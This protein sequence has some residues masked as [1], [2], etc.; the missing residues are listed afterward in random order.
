MRILI[1]NWKDRTHPNAGG[2]EEYTQQ[3][4]KRLVELDH[5]VTLFVSAVEG[6][7]TTE[8]IDG[9]RVI[10]RGSRLGVYSEAKRF[11]GTE[12]AGSFD[13]VVDESNTRPFL[14]PRYVRTVPV[15]GLIHQVAREVWHYETPFPVALAGRYLFEPRWLR[16]YRDVP[17]MTISES[18]AGSLRQYGIKNT[19][20]LPIGADPTENPRVE[21]A[22]HPTMLFLGRLS[23]NKRPDH[24][25]E[26]FRLLRASVPDARLWMMGDGPM[27]DQLERSLPPG[28]QVL[29]HV[30]WEERQRRLGEAHVLVTTSV[31]EG[32]GLNV[33]EAAAVGTPTIGYRVDGLRDSIPASGGHLVDPDPTSMA[34]AVEEFLAGRLALEPRV[35]TVPWATVGDHVE[36]VLS[37]VVDQ[38]R[39]LGAA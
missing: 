12:G 9:Y 4:A 21:S 26:A 36:R 15:V 2:A 5:E 22:P 1:L 28:A 32:W 6:R 33:S 10:R 3:I 34:Q 29:G 13:V 31:R 24:A 35:S 38:G 27:R 20:V 30:T 23:R 7:P 18:S 8:V 16:E 25:M 11:W 19:T 39:D 37:D 14:T 17:V